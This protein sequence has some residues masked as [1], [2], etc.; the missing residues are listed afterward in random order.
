MRGIVLPL[1]AEQRLNRMLYLAK[2]KPI[3]VLDEF[4]MRMPDTPQTC[5]D[6]YYLLHDFNG[7]KNPQ[8]PDPA[9]RWVKPGGK[10]VNRTCDCIGGMAWAG[11]WDRYQPIRFSHI[12][13]GWINTDSMRAD[14]RGPE[15][16]FIKLDKPELGCYVVYGS[17]PH[18]KTHGVPVGHI[19][20]VVG[21]PD[22]WNERD[23]DCW[24][25]MKIV[26]VANRTP[27][28]A[29]KLTSALGWWGK[30]AWFVR[31]VMQP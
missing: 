4:V 8:A 28:P 16:C 12:Y 31:S 17:D 5:P 23:R 30:D 29:N 20:G 18:K 27:K 26:D 2:L 19:G 25:A 22:D 3:S 24:K 11:G 13:Q 15:L 1:S 10:H 6:I 14:A 21:V 7:G 9:D